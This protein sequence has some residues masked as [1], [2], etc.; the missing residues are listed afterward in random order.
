MLLLHIKVICSK[1][2]CLEIIEVEVDES[3][4][5][6]KEISCSNG[7]KIELF[8]PYT[9]YNILF[10][11]ALI[12]FKNGFHFESFH[13]LY[14]GYENFKYTIV[15]YYLFIIFNDIE[16]VLNVS[17]KINRSE[18]IDGAFNI[19][20]ISLFKDVPITLSNKLISERNKVTHNGEIPT[21]A[22]CERLGNSI[23]K[24]VISTH[25]KIDT[26][27]EDAIL[28]EFLH[29]LNEY[30]AKKRGHNV[31]FNNPDDFYEK[32]YSFIGIGGSSLSPNTM[33]PLGHISDTMF[34]DIYDTE[35]I[36]FFQI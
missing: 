36:D 16:K 9:R 1:R 22:M 11:Q 7:H 32:K 19:A 24:L 8:S 6:G 13:T 30:K 14:S 29:S 31:I 2:N 15:Q 35:T 4:F 28:I 25:S 17:K 10:N 33:I 3:V 27:H 18:K 21:K 23:F 34:T 5:S 12:A 26:T 20:Y